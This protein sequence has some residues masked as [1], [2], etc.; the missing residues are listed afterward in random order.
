MSEQFYLSPNGTLI[1]TSNPE[2]SE[3]ECNGNE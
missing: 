2:K 3:S 1:G